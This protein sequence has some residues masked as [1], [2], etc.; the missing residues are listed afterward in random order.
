VGKVRLAL[1]AENI[2]SRPIWPPA[3]RAYASERNRRTCN[4]SF[5]LKNARRKAGNAKEEHKAR[6]IAHSD[7]KRYKARIVG[8]EVSEYLFET[9]LCL[10]FGTQMTDERLHRVVTIIRNCHKPGKTNLA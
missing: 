7:G 1:E 6:G 4:P 3:R 8:G 5:I 9:G 10:P 2:E